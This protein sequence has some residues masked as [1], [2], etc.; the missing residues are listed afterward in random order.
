MLRMHNFF[1]QANLLS[2]KM[3]TPEHTFKSL[4]AAAET[5]FS[6]DT[7][8]GRLYSPKS[9]ERDR[10]GCG[11]RFIVNGLNVHRPTD[12][13]GFLTDDENKKALIHLLLDHW[14]S[15]DMMEDIIRR[16][17]I[18]IEAGQSFQAVTDWPSGIWANARRAAPLWATT[19]KVILCMQP[20]GAWKD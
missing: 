16:P 18:F 11:K 5:A 8:I 19:D 9:A 14:S 13:K 15:H 1:L 7:Y 6:T 2:F 12:W 10:R 17:V 4:P 20:Q 3:E